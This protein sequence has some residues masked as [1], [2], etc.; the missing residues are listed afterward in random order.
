LRPALHIRPHRRKR[1]KKRAKKSWYD[2][3]VA[4]ADNFKLRRWCNGGPLD[5]PATVPHMPT[6]RRA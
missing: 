6:N 1:K 2:R 3:D 4:E 5:I